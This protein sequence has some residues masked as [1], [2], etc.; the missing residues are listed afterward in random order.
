VRRRLALGAALLCAGLA[1]A[2][3]GGGAGLERLDERSGVTLLTDREPIAFARTEARYSRSGRDYLYLG[4]I[5]VNRQGVRE[6][7][8]WVGVGTTLDRGY[9]APAADPPTTLYATVRGEVMELQ[10]RPWAEREPA[11]G[12]R[13]PY[14]TAVPLQA[15][16]A[17]RVTLDQLRL[18]AAESL[19]AVEATTGAA[20]PRLYSRWDAAASWPKFLAAAA[21]A[22]R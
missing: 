16:L 13:A 18:L 21:G 7:Y 20:P 17:A 5:E 14:R 1:A 15:E 10:L 19:D 9:L 11:L 22:S 4:P 12:A 3:R 6:Y 8:L 2:C